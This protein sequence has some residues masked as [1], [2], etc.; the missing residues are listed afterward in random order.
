MTDN[1][2]E[3]IV[4]ELETLTAIC[5][6]STKL[7]IEAGQYTTAVEIPPKYKRHARVF[8]EDE[9]HRFPPSQTW[10]HAINLKPGSP[11]SLNCK[12]YPT[13]PVEKVALK[14]WINKMEEKR[15]IRRCDPNKAYIMMP[16]SLTLRHRGCACA[17]S[18]STQVC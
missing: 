5:S 13:T 6:I 9:S 1:E 8:S 15:Y 10:D 11:D 16:T 18:P 4:E 2:K 12:I 7:V 17:E 14:E 3:A